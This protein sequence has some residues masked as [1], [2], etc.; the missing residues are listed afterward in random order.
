MNI[1]VLKIK[2]RLP[3]NETLKGK[4]QVVRS[5]VARVRNS[6][7]VCIAEVDDQD[8][9]QL[10]TLGITCVSNDAQFANEVL[11]K[12]LNFISN[13]RYDCELLDYNLEVMSVP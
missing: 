10:A 11:S 4:R 1:G 9:W 12:V 2:L 7:N 5:V 6:F 8:Y 3:E 13:C